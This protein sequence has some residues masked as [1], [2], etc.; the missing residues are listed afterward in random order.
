MDG[1]QKWTKFVGSKPLMEIPLSIYLCQSLS[2]SVSLYLSLSL[3]ICIYL[4]LSLSVSIYLYLSLSISIYLYLSPYSIPF[5]SILFW[6]NSIE[7]NSI[8]FNSNS[9]LFHFILFFSDLFCSILFFSILNQ[10]YSFL[11]Y[12]IYPSLSL[13]LSIYLLLRTYVIYVCM[14]IILQYTMYIHASRLRSDVHRALEL[15]FSSFKWH[16]LGAHPPFFDKHKYDIA[17]CISRYILLYND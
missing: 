12:S 16:R 2:I 7:F 11:F 17:Q 4:Y 6:F 1:Y 15:A 8:Q 5:L 13:P 9:I 14:S 3:S 10:F